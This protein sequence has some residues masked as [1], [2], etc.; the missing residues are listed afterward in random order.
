MNCSITI[1]VN[2]LGDDIQCAT[3]NGNIKVYLPNGTNAHLSAENVNG[4]I[5]SD[6]PVT[7]REKIAHKELQ[8]D[9][10]QSGKNVQLETVNGSIYIL[11]LG[12]KAEAE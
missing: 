12:S 6:F 9:I 7:V 8:G 11:K 3:V 10:G 1:T 4:S 2:A 5:K